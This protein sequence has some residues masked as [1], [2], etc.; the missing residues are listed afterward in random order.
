MR[1]KKTSLVEHG[2]K[3]NNSKIPYQMA[4]SYIFVMCSHTFTLFWLRKTAMSAQIF[5]FSFHVFLCA[6]PMVISS[7]FGKSF[8]FP[9]PYFGLSDESCCTI[10]TVCSHTFI[11]FWLRKNSV[12]VKMYQLS[13]CVLFWFICAFI[14]RS[15]HFFHKSFQFLFH[16]LC[17]PYFLFHVVSNMKNVWM[18]NNECSHT[19]RV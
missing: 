11:L 9:F 10:F 14:W 12:S 6:C 7:I 17:Y 19:M 4:N 5:W 3:K 16:F 15:L 18:L 8:H 1:Y 2:C 13:L